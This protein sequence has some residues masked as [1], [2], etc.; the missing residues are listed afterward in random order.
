ME[1]I[2]FAEVKCRKSAKERVPFCVLSAFFLRGGQGIL[3]GGR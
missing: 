1:V 3:V 2:D